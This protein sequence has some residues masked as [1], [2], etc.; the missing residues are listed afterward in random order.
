MASNFTKNVISA[1]GI[2]DVKYNIKAI[3][4]HATE[5]EWNSISYIPKQGEFIVYDVDSNNTSPRFKTGDGVTDVKNLPFTLA[6]ISE[7]QAYVNSQIG[8]AGHLK[9]IVLEDG[10]EL[11]NV[12][13]ADVDTIYMKRNNESRLISDVFDEYM[14]INGAWEIIGNT[15]VDLS[16]YT[17]QEMVDEKIE[18]AI[19]NIDFPEEIYINDK[20]PENPQENALWLDTDERAAVSAKSVQYIPQTLTEEQQMQARA[21]MGL[22]RTEKKIGTVLTETTVAIDPEVGAAELTTVVPFMEGQSCTVT[23]NGTEYVCTTLVPGDEDTFVL[24]NLSIEGGED[25][26]EP[27]CLVCY[28]YGT[29]IVPLDGSETVTLSITG[30]V[31]SVTKIPEKYLPSVGA[32]AEPLEVY[33]EKQNDTY[34]YYSTN[35]T[36]SEIK[37]AYNSGRVIKLVIGEA[38]MYVK[39]VFTGDEVLYYRVQ[40]SGDDLVKNYVYFAISGGSA[41]AQVFIYRATTALTLL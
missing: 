28:P 13:E 21:N 2:K 19:S 5:S 36:Y 38:N 26:G 1:I 33:C 41:T 32:D 6:T 22:Y 12:N 14:I 39:P 25:T 30:M 9:R 4:F 35:R 20:A 24:G 31:E 34:E 17:T 7:V 8:S 3:P 16:D 27:F 29:V 11:P 10:A 18:T 23:W 37:N 15:R 40:M